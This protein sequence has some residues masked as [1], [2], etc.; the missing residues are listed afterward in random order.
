MPNSAERAAIFANYAKN[1]AEAECSHIGEK[2]EGLSG[3]NIKDICEFTERRWA[4]K[5]I[6]KKLKPSAPPF[7]FYMQTLR[8][9]KETR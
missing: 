1:L 8:M 3:R 2:S 9:W 5:I 6:V 7:E 4:R